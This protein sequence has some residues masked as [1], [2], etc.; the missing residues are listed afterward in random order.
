[1]QDGLARREATGR[2]TPVGIA[3]VADQGSGA[4]PSPAAGDHVRD[5]TLEEFGRL[6]EEIDNH[7]QFASALVG[8]CLTSLGAGLALFE[9]FPDILIAL[10]V[11]SSLL[12]LQWIDHSAQ[13]L[14]IATYIAVRLSSRLR[15]ADR[16]PLLGWEMFLRRLDEDGQ[17]RLNAT[18]NI[19]QH[20]AWLFGGVPLALL[21]ILLARDLADLATGVAQASVWIRLAGL[22]V[23]AAPWLVWVYFYLG[24]RQLKGQL[25]EAVRIGVD[26][27]TLPRD[28]GD[29]SAPSSGDATRSDAVSAGA[30]PSPPAATRS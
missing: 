27:W 11:A 15:D 7:M 17:F 20:A 18:K 8:A 4:H 19:H 2:L 21:T 6:R 5:V 24:F 10:A 1:M 30:S 3:E 28:D 23:A 16:R 9:R 25:D 12:G 14:K 13:I 22:L 26:P 29:G